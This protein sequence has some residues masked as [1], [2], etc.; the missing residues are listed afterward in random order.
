MTPM[1]SFDKGRY[2]LRSL[3][4][5]ILEKETLDLWHGGNKHAFVH[6]FSLGGTHGYEKK[7][8]LVE[9]F[10]FCPERMPG[11]VDSNG[12]KQCHRQI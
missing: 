7:L 10:P 4:N 3:Q 12:C 5:I 8:V 6:T 2:S 9:V 11:R 1:S